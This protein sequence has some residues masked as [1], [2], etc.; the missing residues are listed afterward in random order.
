MTDQ[1]VYSALEPKEI[2]QLQEIYESARAVKAKFPESHIASKAAS[3]LIEAFEAVFRAG[4][5]DLDELWLSK[6][7]PK[8]NA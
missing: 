6:A 7:K 4:G 3:R 5:A 1:V 2:R 8:G